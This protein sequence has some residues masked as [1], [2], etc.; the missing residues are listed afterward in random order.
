MTYKD[1]PLYQK[2]NGINQGVKDNLTKI[3]DFRKDYILESKK[4]LLVEAAIIKNLLELNLT[5]LL[6][7]K[8]ILFGMNKTQKKIFY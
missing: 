3:A 6:S 4:F 7:K 5:L 1:M 8:Q 2:L